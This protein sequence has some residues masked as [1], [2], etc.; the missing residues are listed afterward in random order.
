MD[1]LVLEMEV[2]NFISSVV[3]EKK[4][5]LSLK[6][7]HDEC[8]YECK[9]KFPTAPSQMIIRSEKSV[10]STFKTIKSNKHKIT[11]APV[12]KKL[13][14]QLD[15]RLYSLKDDCNIRITTL[16]KNYPVQVQF[17]F[18]DKLIEM[19]NNYEVADP[20]LFVK[21]D[22]IWIA[23]P[24]KSPTKTLVSNQTSTGVDLG[25]N[26]VAVTSDGIIFRDK[27]FNGLK[28]K[29]R[30]LKRE[31]NSK[32]DLRKGGK[33]KTKAIRRKLKNL[34]NK[35]RNLSKHGAHCLSKQIV[36]TSSGNVIV[37]EDL[38]KIKQN[39][40]RGKKF[41]NKQSQIPYYMIKEFMIYK[42]LLAGK[43]VVTVN[44]AYTSQIDFRTGNKD[45]VRQN[46]RY[47]GADGKVLNADI[48]ASLNIA[49]RSKLPVSCVQ[50]VIYGQGAIN[51]PYFCK[52]SK[53]LEV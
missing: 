18:Y 2:W 52:S 40:K 24:F 15:K 43:K 10:L 53:F 51:H 49:K 27:H 39:T 16:T 36:E 31:L 19:F 20:K 17:K 7:I 41:N 6:T 38:T 30:H 3:F 44:P 5:I 12:R 47:V 4:I 35:E 1:M 32:N 26:R 14:I 9:S 28:R 13:S 23:F 37:F 48:N 25:I 8:Y 22:V 29:V 46:G 11:K 34:R 21:D 45:G 42:A 33:G 50:D